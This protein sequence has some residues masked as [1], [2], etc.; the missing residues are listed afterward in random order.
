VALFLIDQ[1]QVNIYSVSIKFGRTIKISS[2]NNE[3][4]KL[5]K[6]TATPTLVSAPFVLIDTIKDYNQISRIITLYWRTSLDNNQDYYIDVVNL[7][8]SSGVIVGSEKVK[9]TYKTSSTPSTQLFQAP[10]LVPILI[11]DKSIKKDVD[12]SYQILAKNPKFY[13]DSI[14]PVNGDFYLDNSYGNGRVIVT[15][16]ER[17]ASNF[18]SNKYFKAQRKKIQK[19]PS[20]WESV[21]TRV[22]MHSWKPEVYIDFPSNDATPVY[23]EEEK[24]YYETGYKYR[25]IVSKDVGI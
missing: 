13:I 9:F 12:I 20:R 14:D 6:D 15:F 24:I 8:D 7:I 10:E 1:A 5:Y 21:E 4:F 23:N 17:P 18:L 16:N 22:L 19:S 11:E 3:N 2:L 25:I